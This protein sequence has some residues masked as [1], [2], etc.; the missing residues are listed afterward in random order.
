MDTGGVERAALGDRK[1]AARITRTCRPS[2]S[3][4]CC[5]HFVDRGERS[6]ASVESKPKAVAIAS[7][8]EE[9]ER[10]PERKPALHDASRRRR[11][12]NDA[13]RGEGGGGPSPPGSRIT[14]LSAGEKQKIMCAAHKPYAVTT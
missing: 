5:E 2:V 10:E 4:E 11:D 14:S 3:P 7:Q 8:A 1:H 6:E 12:S 13:C 9:A